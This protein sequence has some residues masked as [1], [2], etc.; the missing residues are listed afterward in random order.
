M[1]VV[2]GVVTA[3]P[4]AL[5]GVATK[6]WRVPD[7]EKLLVGQTPDDRVDGRREHVEGR[8]F[9]HVAPVRAQ[10]PRTQSDDRHCAAGA[11]ENSLLHGSNGTDPQRRYL[12]GG[13]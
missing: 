4:D 5:G 7:A 6:P 12:R 11:A 13:R 8:R 1:T 2:G 9:R 3:H 10:L